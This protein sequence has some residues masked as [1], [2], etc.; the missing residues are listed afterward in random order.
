MLFVC[1]QTEYEGQIKTLTQ[2]IDPTTDGIVVAG[3]DGT[4]LEVSKCK[5]QCQITRGPQQQL[6]LLRSSGPGSGINLRLLQ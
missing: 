3:G 5:K 1:S 6:L 2:Y 4:L